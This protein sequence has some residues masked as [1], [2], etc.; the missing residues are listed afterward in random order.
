MRLFLLLLTSFLT[1]NAAL[2]QDDILKKEIGRMIV[3]GFE[4]ESVN[5]ESQIVKEIQKYDL[6]GVILFD[7]FYKE[8]SITK[9]I[10]SPTQLKKLTSKLKSFSKKPL[11]ISIDQEGG[12]VA[13]LKPHYGFSK[14]PSAY[15]ASK[16]S[17]EDVK[18]VYQT[19]SQML[20]AV[21]VNTNF[22]PVVD[23]A[24]NPDNKVIVGLERSFGKSAQKV[25]Q[26]AQIVIDSQKDE[27]IISVFKT[28]S[29]TWF[30]S[31]R[32]S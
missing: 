16:M 31:W 32:F 13:R 14:I 18:K 2:P 3:V 29:W 26:Y 17:P 15:E 22:A 8:R 28:L 11:L 12:K 27:N 7:K 19:Q 25:V 6:G 21:G 30:L 1:L 20:N 24:V 5:A 9:N 10:S 4:G 23:L